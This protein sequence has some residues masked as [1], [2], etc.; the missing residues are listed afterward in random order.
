MMMK[1]SVALV[2]GFVLTACSSNQPD[3]LDKPSGQ[4]PPQ[5]Y[6][7][8]VGEADDRNTADGRALANLAKIFE[9]AI[10]D[11]SLDFALA[12]VSS[13]QSGSAQSS[14]TQNTERYL[15]TE[16]RQVLEGG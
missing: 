9:V 8:A 1:Y 6:L 12:R 13:D 15:T 16:A 4:Y 5:R 14:N 10:L 3:W 11:R 2:L 7:S